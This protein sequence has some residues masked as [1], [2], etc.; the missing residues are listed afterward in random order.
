MRQLFYDRGL[1]L[2]LS[3]CQYK[4]SKDFFQLISFPDLKE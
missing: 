3:I 1:D 2:K 4:V